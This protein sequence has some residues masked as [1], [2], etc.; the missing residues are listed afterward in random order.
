MFFFRAWTVEWAGPDVGRVSVEQSLEPGESI[1]TSDQ[2]QRPGWS[3]VVPIL[4]APYNIGPVSEA[5]LV[6]LVVRQTR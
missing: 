3:L 6:M 2:P 4:V 1:E 5:G